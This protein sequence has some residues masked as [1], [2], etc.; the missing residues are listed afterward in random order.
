MTD[1]RNYSTAPSYETRTHGALDRAEGVIVGSGS[2]PRA[3][4]AGL[5]A[6]HRNP[7]DMEIANRRNRIIGGLVVALMLGAAGAYV[8]TMLPPP[9]NQVVSD[10]DLPRP[11]SL[12]EA[13]PQTPAAS[14]DASLRSS[15]MV[16]AAPEASGPVQPAP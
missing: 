13:M 8:Y 15:P 5:G 3:V 16:P 14:P 11:G 1:T 7:A 6:F 12:S 9:E 10:S 2:G 4:D